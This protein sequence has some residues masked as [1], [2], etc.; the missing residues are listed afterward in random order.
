MDK[1]IK[2]YFI[3]FCTLIV[4]LIAI[5]VSVFVTVDTKDNED[6]Y[7]SV[8]SLIAD[9]NINMKDTLINW[10]TYN[11]YEMELTDSLVIISG[12]VYRLSGKIDDGMI[13]VNTDEN[14]KLILDDI[15]IY[16]PVGPAIYVKDA[17]NTLI[18]L[19]E[20]TTNILGTGSSFNSTDEDVEG[21]IYSKDDIV[22][23]GTGTL[24]IISNYKDAIL[25]KD[26]IKILNGNYI[27]K[28]NDDAIRAR[29]YLYIANGK[30]DI[31]ARGDGIKASNEDEVNKGFLLIENGIFDISVVNDAIQSENDI[32]INNGNFTITTLG[33]GNESSNVLNNNEKLE[34]NIN[35]SDSAKGIKAEH[36]IIINDGTFSFDTHDDAL[37]SEK[38]IGIKNG[39]FKIKVNSRNYADAIHANKEL[40]IDG[41]IIDV[42][43]SYEG[44]ESDYILINGGD[45][46]ILSS[47]DGINVTDGNPEMMPGGPGGPGGPMG[48]TTTS[49]SDSESKLLLDIRDGNIYVNA[50]GDGLDSN[51][52]ITMSGG[53]VVVDGPINDG[54]ATLDYAMSFT[55]TGGTV[56]ATGS[57]GMAQTITPSKNYTVSFY[58]PNI[59]AGSSIRILNSNRDEV[60][61]HIAQKSFN[62]IAIYSDKFKANETYILEINGVDAAINSNFDTTFKFTSNSVSFTNPSAQGGGMGMGGMPT[63]PGGMGGMPT[64]P[65][66][67]G[68]GGGTP[69]SAPP[70]GF[71]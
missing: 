33:L 49:N 69:P 2:G 43:Q 31:D 3:I 23:D 8:E 19:E 38:Y 56:I 21:C 32:I 57:S 34:A 60:I 65:G 4:M 1:E 70:G 24:S 30:F 52:S 12:G 13:I 50:A 63:P 25:S 62:F 47:D 61:S 28:S 68:M 22:F 40:L 26:S 16:N 71:R 67:M 14:V 46:K 44:F 18:Y 5:L 9:Y 41:G 48:G 10:D 7:N 6:Y 15:F 53:Y 55:A 17:N 37:H 35:V 20:G 51:G 39:N 42:T 36:Y 45:I 64:P 54:N 59:G 11:Q 66:G 29:D 27:I 58:L